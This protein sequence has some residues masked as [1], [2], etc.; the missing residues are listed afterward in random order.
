MGTCTEWLQTSVNE[1][2]GTVGPWDPWSS[3]WCLERR[4]HKSVRGMNRHPDEYGPKNSVPLIT[5][6]QGKILL[7]A[8]HVMNRSDPITQ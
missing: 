4:L 3:V 1:R 6:P 5:T 8:F 2:V 7:K